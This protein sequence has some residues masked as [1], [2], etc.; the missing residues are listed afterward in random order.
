MREKVQAALAKVRPMLQ[1]DGG[2]VVLID[3][4][5]DGIVKVQLTGACKGCPM[6]QMTLK[7]GIE[8]FIRAEIPEIRAV[9]SV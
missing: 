1:Q 7:N 9:E 8:K 4:T 3:V 5:D 6:S 2:D